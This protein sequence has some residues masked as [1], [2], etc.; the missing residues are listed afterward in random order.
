M[1][2]MVHKST[3]MDSIVRLSVG[4]AHSPGEKCQ[5]P[6]AG[7]SETRFKAREI[8][9]RKHVWE[10]HEEGRVRSSLE[11]WEDLSAVPT[12]GGNK[13]REGRSGRLWSQTYV[14]DG[15]YVP[16]GAC[17]STPGVPNR[18]EHWPNTN[19]SR[20]SDQPRFLSVVCTFVFCICQLWFQVVCL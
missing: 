9:C 4:R 13:G 16:T 20:Q 7:A 10:K 1:W 12:Q 15:C 8:H 11:K 6:P 3:D 18:E 17:L 5:S 14:S 2:A 19:T